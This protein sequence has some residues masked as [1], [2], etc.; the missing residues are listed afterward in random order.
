MNEIC[1]YRQVTSLKPTVVDSDDSD[2][3][4]DFE[5]F[6]DSEDFKGAVRCTEWPRIVWFHRNG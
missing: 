3:S 5:D 2:D 4:D 1:G 6:K